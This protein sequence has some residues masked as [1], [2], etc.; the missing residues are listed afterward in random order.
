MFSCEYCQI[1]ENN[2][3][4]EYLRMAAFETSAITQ[5]TK[6]FFMFENS[7]YGI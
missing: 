7:T 6:L 4:E 1:F 5:F 3:L 2:Y